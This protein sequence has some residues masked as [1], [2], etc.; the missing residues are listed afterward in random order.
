MNQPDTVLAHVS[1]THFTR[2]EAP[3]G[4]RCRE[5]LR[6]VLAAIE[7]RRQP[8]AAML[9]TG[10]LTEDGDPDAYVDLA[11]IVNESAARLG[12]RVVW[13]AGNHD[14]REVYSRLLLGRQSGEPGLQV[15]HIDGLRIIA[16]DSTVPGRPHGELST[17]TLTALRDELATPAPRGTVVALHHPPIR[18][19]LDFMR[20]MTLHGS[21]RFAA[22]L[23][24]TDVRAILAGHL[25]HPY[26]SL[27]AG[28]PLVI[29]TSVA[30]PLDLTAPPDQVVDLDCPPAYNHIAVYPDAIT[31][32]VVT[33][34]D[35][36]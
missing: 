29:A 33:V 4:H 32:A 22:A 27:F 5:R 2:S 11:A 28:I 30:R 7:S 25:H 34:R 35:H 12:T 10:D 9:V 6:Q 15:L 3:D 19:V 8:P 18:P 13:L 17:V 26:F 31:H 23:A 24:G 1:D 20:D 14:V 36:R 21:E 16:L